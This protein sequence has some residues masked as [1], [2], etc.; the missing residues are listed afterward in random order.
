M[1]T[2]SEHQYAA[3]LTLLPHVSA[4]RQAC[5]LYQERLGTDRGVAARIVR[6]SHFGLIARPLELLLAATQVGEPAIYDADARRLLANDDLRRW[7]SKLEHLPEGERDEW[8]ATVAAIQSTSVELERAL[9]A[10][11]AAAQG[12]TEPT[13]PGFKLLEHV[14]RGGFGT[15]FRAR[16]EAGIDR[17][18]KLLEPSALALQENAELRFMREGTLLASIDHANVVKYIQLGRWG[19]GWYLVMEL[20]RG[21]TLAQWARD[22][23]PAVRV[24]AILRV[25]DGVS[26]LHAAGVFHR[27]LKPSNILVEEPS[28]RPVVVDLGM[29]WLAGST[30]PTMTRGS[31]WSAAYAP[32]EVI[33]DP[34]QSRTPGHD[35]YSIGVILYEVLCGQRPSTA[36][37]I[38]LARHDP[39]LEPFDDV[40]ARALAIPDLRFAT[41]EEFSAAVRRAADGNLS[42]WS[43]VLRDVERVQS[44]V[45]RE[46]LNAG[47]IAG[48]ASD[49]VDVAVITA[50]FFQGL[51]IHFT[52]AYRM[53]RGSDAY[54]FEQRLPQRLYG[55]AAALF[56]RQPMLS[57]E[58]ML[59][60]DE[61]GSAALSQLGFGVAEL[62]AIQTAEDYA[63][64]QLGAAR[65]PARDPDGPPPSPQQVQGVRALVRVILELEQRESS[66]IDEFA[67]LAASAFETPEEPQ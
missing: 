64:Q 37:R 48:E 11:L 34:A 46:L 53:A 27:D 26:A 57:W 9:R 65:D 29:S 44:P 63:L 38:P 19:Q 41:T 56:R 36:Q 6:R 55:V 49:A 30:D 17:A 43:T 15:V 61:H 51:R 21:R 58:V 25:L 23:P 62:A 14:G 42:P 13:V 3:I 7:V 50:G 16:D 32:P 18:V 28:G 47:V 10:V 31:A 12:A 20:V 67:G 5:E 54:R 24:D 35:I 2:P 8:D 40:V 52:R 39:Q 1:T 33:A 45:L 59:A 22:Q 4:A 66:F 60:E